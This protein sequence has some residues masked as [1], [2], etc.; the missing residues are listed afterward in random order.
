M[1]LFIWKPEYSVND[2]VLDGHHQQLFALLNAVYEN[3]MNSP[4]IE[5]VLPE[6]DQLS[7]YTKYHFSSE[8]AYMKEMLYAGISE[9]IE[10]HRD[11]TRA[12]EEL[13]TNYHDNDLE[14]AKSLIIVLGEWLLGHVLKED[15]KYVRVP[16]NS[17]A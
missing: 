14:S 6:I 15:M 11:F 1:S 8:E 7:T 5:C 9:H 12:V 17:G 13:R 4:E 10:A 16:T 2:T 3:V